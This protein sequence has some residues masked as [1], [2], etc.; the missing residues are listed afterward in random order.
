MSLYPQKTYRTPLF[1]R[2]L[3]SL[4]RSDKR[5]AAAAER[6]EK[7]LCA[8]ASGQLSDEELLIRQTK[9][10]ELRLNNCRKFDIGSGYRLISIRGNGG[11]CFVCVGTHDVCDRW[12]NKRRADGFSLDHAQ[13]E[14]VEI[15]PEQLAKEG[16]PDELLRAEAKYAAYE[17]EY[18]A[19]IASRLD[20]ETIRYL[21][22]GFLGEQSAAE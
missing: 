13:L 12:L 1:E 2:Q 14:A 7:L 8:I 4:Q 11:L 19:Y 5:G 17:A 16:Q 10:G 9:N 15:D 22:R 6:A 20:E 3:K 21:F 18:E